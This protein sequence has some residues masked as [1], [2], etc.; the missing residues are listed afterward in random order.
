MNYKPYAGP[1]GA[2]GVF[3]GRSGV[4]A[5]RAVRADFSL[6][7]RTLVTQ[8]TSK[9]ETRRESSFMASTPAGLPPFRSPAPRNRPRELEDGLN[10]FVYHP[11][12]FR[13]AQLL[14][15]TGISPNAVSVLGMMCVWAA[16]AAYVGLAW[17]FSVLIG[18]SFH[19]LWHV[20]DG[21]D[22]DLA[23]LTGKSSPAGEMVDGLCDYG[24]H[25]AIYFGL[26]ALIDDQIGLWAWPLGLA[27]A[28]SHAV[29]TNHAETQRRSYLWWA[30]GI[31]WLKHAKA[32]GHEVFEARNAFGHF[33]TWLARCY[34]RAAEAMNPDSAAIDAAVEK[35][36]GDPR[37]TALIR[38]LIRRSSRRSL[39]L[40]KALGA[41][42]RTLILGAC[43]AVGQPL[44]FFLAELVLLNLL[45][46]WSIRHHH[47]TGRRLAQ[48]IG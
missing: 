28:A 38:R 30:Y 16:A 36:D 32:A 25:A 2:R 20:V 1:D 39:M 10:R 11:L 43:M 33:S 5:S 29:Q 23:R 27:A 13:L 15:P 45:L 22:G 44:F 9:Y 26:A 7:S 34:L 24:G 19:M 42:P 37:R 17:P 35:A 6:P 47:R 8:D 41:N 14:R 40:Q 4:A 31:P 21:A 48:K 3:A 12:A 46:I 18:L